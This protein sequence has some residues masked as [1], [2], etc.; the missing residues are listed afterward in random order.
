MTIVG[1]CLTHWP[2][3]AVGSH[4]LIVDV[5]DVIPTQYHD[6]LGKAGI[7]NTQALYKEIAAKK[8]RSS[9]SQKTRIRYATLT[10]WAAFLDLMQIDGIGP[11]MVGLLQASGVQNLLAFQKESASALHT[12]M[13][14]AN[15]GARY[16][17]ILPSVAVVRGW[18]QRAKALPITLE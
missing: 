12:R 1:F 15:R 9:L 11:K 10:Q 14:S 5:P 18:I 6:A 17:E 16:S 8:G 7:R 3:E 13:R 2:S 4:Y